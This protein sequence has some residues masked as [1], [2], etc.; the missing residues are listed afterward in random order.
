MKS[1]TKEQKLIVRGVW[2]LSPY[3]KFGDNI[4]EW[5]RRNIDEILN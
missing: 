2:R 4:K 3:Q 5:I 1:L